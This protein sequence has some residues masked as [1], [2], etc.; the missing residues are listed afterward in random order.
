MSSLWKR[1]VATTTIALVAGFGIT[2]CSSGGG[3][4]T[5]STKS[6]VEQQQTGKKSMT[7]GDFAQ[8]VSDAM[9]AAKTAHITQTMSTQGKD[10][11]STG[12]LMMDPDPQKLRMHLNMSV[13]GQ[14]VKVFLVDGTFYMNMGAM[15][16]DKYVKISTDGSNP[17]AA[18]MQA[19]LG[20]SNAANQMKNAAAAVKEF[21][22]AGTEKVDGAE[23]TH[24][25]LTLDT[26]KLLAAQGVQAAQ[27]AQIGDTL[28]YDLYIDGKDLI[29]RAVMN[30]GAAKTTI[31]YSQWGE[32][33]TIEAPA[34]DQLIE[35]PGI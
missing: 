14:E 22:V 2:A 21:A 23:T 29:R 11:S 8:R 13:G 15:T 6:S 3:T 31:E 26:K 24:Y 9:S 10:V 20:Q 18:Q 33:V 12:E 28:T 4:A 27:A 1:A 25:A 7:A 35:M 19:M 5:E 16:Q 17:L 34:A 32:P 30:M